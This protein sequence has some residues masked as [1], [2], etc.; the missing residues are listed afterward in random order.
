MCMPAQ[1]GNHVQR[2]VLPYA[3]LVLG[4]CRREPVCRH[5]FMRGQ[6]PRQIADL[7]PVRTQTLNAK[8]VSGSLLTWLPVSNSLSNVPC[9]V[10]VFQNLM[11][12]SW[13]PP[14]V[15]RIPGT[16]GSQ[17]SALTAAVCWVNLCSGISPGSSPAA[18]PA[19][20]LEL[21][22]PVLE[23]PNVPLPIP[24]GELPLPRADPRRSH[25]NTL[26]SFPPL[27]SSDELAPSSFD[28]LSPQ[29]SCR[30]AAHFL[31]G[32]VSFSRMSRW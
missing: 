28:H 20:T 1:R 30:C 10:F 11:C 12:L 16:W 24:Y 7:D 3:Y 14:P 19:L 22:D 25:M 5:E 21:V 32:L 13:V 29:T 31:K 15:A 27:A 2:R 6:G 26:L 4:R 18:T 23:C 17:A 9:G 8:R